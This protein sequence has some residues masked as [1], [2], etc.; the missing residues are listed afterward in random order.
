[1]RILLPKILSAHAKPVEKEFDQ[2][3]PEVLLCPRVHRSEAKPVEKG[4][5][6]SGTRYALSIGF[7]APPVKPLP[8]GAF[9]LSMTMAAGAG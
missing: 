4:P 5:R 8:D 1:M 2:N 7:A 9:R 6:L 3:T